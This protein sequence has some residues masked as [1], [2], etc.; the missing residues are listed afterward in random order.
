[1]EISNL[2]A[3][4]ITTLIQSIS[5]F[6][7]GS[8]LNIAGVAGFE[9]GRADDSIPTTYLVIKSEK[10]PL[11][12]W[13]ADFGG[14]DYT[15]M[16]RCQEVSTRL[17]K[18]KRLGRLRYITTGRINGERVICTADSLQD[19]RNKICDALLITLK[20]NDSS[21][22]VLHQLF[23]IKKDKSTIRLGSSLPTMENQNKEDYRDI[24]DYIK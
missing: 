7:S 10:R 1:M 4:G 21:G 23:I 13:T 20:P 8:N 17:Q 12:R 2:I 5:A 14:P 3:V 16:L 9:C 18:Q 15:P 24:E 6:A 22:E 19:A 11:I